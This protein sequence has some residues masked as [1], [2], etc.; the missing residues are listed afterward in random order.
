MILASL[1]SCREL[2]EDMICWGTPDRTRP[3][4]RMRSSG[5]G[6]RTTVKLLSS[7]TFS[8]AVVLA[9]CADD[10]SPSRRRGSAD[11]NVNTTIRGQ[12][13]TD[14]TTT[15]HPDTEQP[16][17]DGGVTS[18][19]HLAGSNESIPPQGQA[20]SADAAGGPSAPGP[21]VN[22]G[23]PAPQLPNEGSPTGSDASAGG[24]TAPATLDGSG[25][26]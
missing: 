6:W 22:E 3:L 21:N 8:L 18:Q 10:L 13:G 19:R 26:D 20:T 9:G 5:S 11:N 15:S 4:P 25:T 14:A 23:T 16:A 24:A 2:L 1:C 7:L 12:G 17:A